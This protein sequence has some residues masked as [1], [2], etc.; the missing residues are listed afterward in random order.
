MDTITAGQWVYANRHEGICIGAPAKS[1]EWYRSFTVGFFDRL[2][3]VDGWQTIA[4]IAARH[5]GAPT[6][7]VL[8]NLE[9]A[10]WAIELDIVRDWWGGARGPLVGFDYVSI[11]QLQDVQN[12]EDIRHAGR[13]AKKLHTKKRRSQFAS[14]RS[15]LILALLDSGVPYVCAHPACDISVNLTIDHRKALSRGGSDDLDNLQFMCVGHNSQKRD[16]P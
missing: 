14:V 1:G 5:I 8:Y 11:E 12:Q 6:D 15:D 16:G 2:F 3:D 9:R 10:R 4:T 7:D 13:A